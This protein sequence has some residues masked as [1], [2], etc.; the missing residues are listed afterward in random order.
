MSEWLPTKSV[1]RR[2]VYSPEESFRR[3]GA[4]KEFAERFSRFPRPRGYV[5]KLRTHEEYHLWRKAQ[6]NPRLW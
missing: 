4:L 6:E 5:L 1:G 3:A 2:R